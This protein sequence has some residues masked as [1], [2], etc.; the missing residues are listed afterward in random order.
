M[1]LGPDIL[2]LPMAIA[3]A[4]SPGA[5]ALSC[6]VP[7]APHIG[8]K[9]VTEDIV[10]DFS[11]PALGLSQMKNDTVSPYAKGTD[12]VSGGLREDHPLIKTQVEWQVE[13]DQR[14]NTACMW[15]DQITITI[16]LKPKIYVAREFNV[17]GC[18]E[19]VLNHEHKHVDVDRVVINRFA[20]GIG[21]AV[22]KVVDK[23]GV[24]G[25]FDFATVED[26]KVRSSG[27][28]STMV[29]GQKKI[30]EAEMRDLQGQVD[31]LQEYERVSS[32]CSDVKLPRK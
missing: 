16:E 2:A 7:K 23:V 10:Y 24:I 12:T 4:A 1:F 13:I 18:R 11:Q 6:H 5:Q 14:N 22:Q 21:Q 27:Y 3:L 30:M 19:A 29:D 28:I 25:P 8:V 31:S 20:A 32:Y 9:V 26:V 17:E 15:Y